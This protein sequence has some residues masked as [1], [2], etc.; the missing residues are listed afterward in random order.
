MLYSKALTGLS[1]LQSLTLNFKEYIFFGKEIKSFK[2][3]IR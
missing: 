1:S 3:L 2:A